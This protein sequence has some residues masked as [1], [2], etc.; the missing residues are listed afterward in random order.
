MNPEEARLLL[1]HPYARF[2]ICEVGQPA[3]PDVCLA[4]HTG[5]RLPAPPPQQWR[6][7][8]AGVRPAHLWSGLGLPFLRMLLAVVSLKCKR[9]TVTFVTCS[10]GR[11]TLQGKG[12]VLK[13]R[14]CGGPGQRAGP[15][16]ERWTL[17]VPT[18]PPPP[19]QLPSQLQGE[20]SQVPPLQGTDT[21][22]TGLKGRLLRSD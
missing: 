14:G 5:W 6:D 12:K 20:S 19:H 11:L 8:G 13:D 16:S 4:C 15:R 1:S 10:G 7:T 9:P 18:W 3:G 21:H 17:W 22:V 2:L